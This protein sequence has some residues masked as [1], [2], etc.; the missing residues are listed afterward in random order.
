M[1]CGHGIKKFIIEKIPK[2][3][4][5]YETYQEINAYTFSISMYN[6]TWKKRPD[7]CIFQLVSEEV[8]DKSVMKDLNIII[9]KMTI[10][11]SI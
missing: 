7:I 3:D 1:G 4:S 6:L 9:E 8:V 2:K 10:F 11:P 5:L